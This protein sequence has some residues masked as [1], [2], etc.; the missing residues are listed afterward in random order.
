MVHVCSIVFLRG[1]SFLRDKQK[2][3]AS[4]VGRKKGA[5]SF[6]QIHVQG[7][8]LPSPFVMSHK[9]KP[10]VLYSA[11]IST[12]ETC[13]L[14]WFHRFCGVSLRVSVGSLIHLRR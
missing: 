8:A 5:G 13:T 12:I 9:Q 11:A 6:R 3:Q 2:R 4:K 1:L 14:T 7:P 10:P